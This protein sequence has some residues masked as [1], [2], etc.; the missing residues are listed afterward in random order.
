MPAGASAGPRSTALLPP[1][2]LHNIHYAKW[3]MGRLSWVWLWIKSCL[4]SREPN[5]DEIA[6]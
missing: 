3:M 4:P 5:K 1:V 2:V 6:A